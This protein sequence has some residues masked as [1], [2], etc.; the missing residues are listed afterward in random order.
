ELAEEVMRLA[1]VAGGGGWGEGVA[2]RLPDRSVGNDGRGNERQ[3]LPGSAMLAEGRGA[4]RRDR[5]ST[6]ATAAALACTLVLISS[7]NAAARHSTPSGPDPVVAEWP[8]WPYLTSC[9]S[10]P[11]DPVTVFGGA[12]SAERVRGRPERKLRRTIA[13]WQ[14]YTPT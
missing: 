6:V 3:A 11:F 1:G 4:T 13:E 9:D 10:A 7:A 8:S 2:K 5:W 12:T 14:D